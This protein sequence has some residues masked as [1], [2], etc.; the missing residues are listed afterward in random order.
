MEQG[1]LYYKGRLVIPKASKLLPTIIA[2]FHASPMGGHSGETK[3]YQCLAAELFWVRMCKDILKF[4]QECTICQQNKYLATTPVGLLQ[5]IPLSAQ[6]WDEVTMD[7]IEGLPCSE[8]WDT[9]L[10]VVDRLSK[11]AHFI[12][13]KHPFREISVAGVFIKEV[14]CLHGIP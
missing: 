5:P 3:T 9:I 10:V 12:G 7:F 11:Y 8:G 13:L 2:K 14:V 6:V 4:V 1:V